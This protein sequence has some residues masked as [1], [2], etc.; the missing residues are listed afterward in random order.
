MKMRWTS[1]QE[2]DAGDG[3]EEMD[4]QSLSEQIGRLSTMLAIRLF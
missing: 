1:L 4:G 2:V 3:A